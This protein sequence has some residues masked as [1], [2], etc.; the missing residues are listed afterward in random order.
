M[1]Y[2][3][4]GLFI[5]WVVGIGLIAHERRDAKS[6]AGLGM[7]GWAGAIIAAVCL[8]AFFWSAAAQF[9]RVVWIIPML[10]FWA[11]MI[12]LIFDQTRRRSW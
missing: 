4:G 3:W 2:I 1:L 7:M 9:G 10:G 12:W 5:P 6:D 8:I 11:F